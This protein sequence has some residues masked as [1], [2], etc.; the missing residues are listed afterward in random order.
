[1]T[2]S[3]C[4]KPERVVAISG[5]N[6]E[7][8]IKDVYT[9]LRRCLDSSETERVIAISGGPFGAMHRMWYGRNGLHRK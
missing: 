4:F 9:I 2:A 3:Q 7:G 5:G 8:P 1:M 6:F